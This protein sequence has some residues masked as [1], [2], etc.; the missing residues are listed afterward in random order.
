LESFRD[1]CWVFRNTRIKYKNNGSYITD[2]FIDLDVQFNEKNVIQFAPIIK[3]YATQKLKKN[4][5]TKI[6]FYTLMNDYLNKNEDYIDTVLDLEL[7]RLRNKLPNV[8]VT[9]D[10]KVL[11]L[12]YRG[13]KQDMKYGTHLNL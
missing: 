4:N 7:T 10:R 1:L 8:I 5:I 6:E 13:N 2:F 9:P 3:I 11:N 12:I